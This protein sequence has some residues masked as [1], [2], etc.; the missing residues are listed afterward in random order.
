M[1][2]CVPYGGRS[3]DL[4]RLLSSVGDSIFEIYGAAPP[5]LYGS[6]R[7]SILIPSTESFSNQVRAVHDYGLRFNAIMNATCSDSQ[8]LDETFAKTLKSYL[9]SLEQAEVDTVTV[10]DPFLVDFISTNF[11]NFEA[12]VSTAAG[13]DCAAKAEYFHELGAK[14]IVIPSDINRN[15]YALKELLSYGKCVFEII[16]NEGC[17]YKCPYYFFHANASSHFSLFDENEK[18][19]HA[20]QE[21]RDQYYYNRCLSMRQSNP[22]L[23]FSSPWIRP[24]D[25]DFY[26]NKFGLEYVKLAGRQLPTEQIISVVKAYSCK[27]YSGNLLALLSTPYKIRENYYI[28]NEGLQKIVERLNCCGHQCVSCNFCREIAATLAPKKV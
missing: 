19:K 16:P 8:V 25:I 10:A 21:F 14:R 5:G 13:V 12:V 3:E 17:L 9:S 18:S 2:L 28:S 22:S 15:F 7:T 26:L 20:R 23:F 24:E 27:K 6:L 1:K 4:S 11:P